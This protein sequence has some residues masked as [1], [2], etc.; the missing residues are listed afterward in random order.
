[1][2]AL[3][4]DASFVVALHVADD[5]RHNDAAACWEEVCEDAPEIVTTSYVFMELIALLNGRGRHRFAVA[6]GKALLTS[7]DVELEYVERPVFETAWKYLE[8]HDDKTYSLT[9][10]VSFVLMK[11]RRISSALTFD[12]HFEQAG[13]EMLPKVKG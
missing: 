12:R 13:F 1:M 8:K 3:F 6:V 2:K 10:C 9:D 11:E 5:R 4:L 7:A